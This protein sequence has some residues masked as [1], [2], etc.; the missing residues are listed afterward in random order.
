VIAVV[1]KGL[2]QN[3]EQARGALGVV[4]IVAPTSPAKLS[5]GESASLACL[6]M[7]SRSR[8]MLGHPAEE[9]P[10]IQAKSR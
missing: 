3:G 6:T 8:T 1:D 10:A 7:R 2:P 5:G 4:E 9:L